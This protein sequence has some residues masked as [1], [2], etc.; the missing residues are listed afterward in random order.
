MELKFLGKGSAFNNN[1]L[2]TSAYFIKGASL[3]LIACGETV[4]NELMNKGILNKKTPQ[5]AVFFYLN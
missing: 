4:F 3:Y 5:V 2:N 1:L